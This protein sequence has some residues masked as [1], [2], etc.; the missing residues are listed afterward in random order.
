M[1]RCSTV[2]DATRHDGGPAWRLYEPMT[3]L[4][5]LAITIGAGWLAARLLAATTAVAPALLAA[6]F[7]SVALA[8]L[9]GGVVH[10]AGAQLTK[11]WRWPLWRLAL[12]LAALTNA[13]LLAAVL[14]A[15][16][17]APWLAPSLAV[18]AVKLLVVGALAVRTHEFRWVVYDSLVT[19]AAVGAAEGVAWSL[20]DA[21]SGPWMLGAVVVSVLAGLVQQ[22]RI[23]PH[24]HF[25]HNDLYHVVQLVAIYLFY[26]GGLLLAAR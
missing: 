3:V 5:D 11:R 8:A 6:C 1:W 18:A 15:G 12:L 7:V 2:A 21:A 22:A 16:V 9:V 4:T 20:R 14:V 25:N 23:A 26:R 17:A 13:L 24:R 10:G 19:F